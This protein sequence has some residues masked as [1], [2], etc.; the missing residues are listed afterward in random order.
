MSKDI[1]IDIEDR[2]PAGRI[3]ESCVACDARDAFTYL[4]KDTLLLKCRKCGLVFRL[5]VPRDAYEH[6]VIRHYTEVD[7]A[8]R[9]AESRQ[10]LY[11][12]FLDKIEHKKGMGERLLDIGCGKGYFLA[13]AKEYGWQVEGVDIAPALIDEGRALFGLELQCGN[14]REMD[15]AGKRF[16]VITIWNVLEETDDPAGVVQKCKTVLRPGGLLFI[17]TPNSWFHQAAMA[18]VAVV[19]RFGVKRW[20]AHQT[21]IFHRYSFSASV[22]KRLL[23]KAG[24]RHVTVCNSCP[25]AGD[26]YAVGAG[27]GGIKRFLYGVAQFAYWL[28]GRQVCLSSSI[29]VYA[30]L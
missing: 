24:Y 5:P 16:D 2:N 7:P 1:I 26:P 4:N 22:I 15:L 11:K 30:E 20:R 10:G 17:R 13:R 28:T 14:I 23:H 8:L 18:F 25:T 6:R 12:R 29:E 19:D 3:L 21:F 9:V 27:V